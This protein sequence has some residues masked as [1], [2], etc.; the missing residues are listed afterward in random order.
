M[1]VL[2]TNVV[3][4]TLR[5]RPDARLVQWID[6]QS[7]NNELYLC[8]PVVAELR[9]GAESMPRG[10]QQAALAEAIGKIEQVFEGRILPLDCEAARIYGRVMARRKATGRPILT[11]DAL[12]A[13]IVLSHQGCLATRNT[14]DFAD[15]GLT[16][17]NPFEP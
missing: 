2:D 4:E 1:I 6:T 12:I 5:I 15:L 16:L 17:I 11:M 8:A 14:R 7:D 10:R 3:S 13:A 9:Y